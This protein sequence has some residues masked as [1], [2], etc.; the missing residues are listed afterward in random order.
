M[1]AATAAGIYD[2]V[3]QAMEQM[4]AGFDAEYLPDPDTAAAYDQIYKQ[5]QDFGAAVEKLS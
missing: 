4:G 5:Y 2:N 1:F 3:S